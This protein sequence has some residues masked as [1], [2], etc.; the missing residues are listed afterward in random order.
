MDT[1]YCFFNDVVRDQVGDSDKNNT[2]MWLLK[3]KLK[4]TSTEQIQLQ[5]KERS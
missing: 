3:I 2:V 5:K 1:Y 4:P